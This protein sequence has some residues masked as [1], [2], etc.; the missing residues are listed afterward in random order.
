[1]NALET[2]IISGFGRT[3]YDAPFIGLMEANGK[4]NKTLKGK[5]GNAEELGFFGGTS[6]RKSRRFFVIGASSGGLVAY[7]VFAGWFFVRHSGWIKIVE[8]SG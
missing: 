4:A 6:N 1:V 5:L 2:D 8:K 7:L 3:A